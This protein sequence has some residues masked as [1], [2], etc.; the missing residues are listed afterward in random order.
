MK[1]LSLFLLFLVS[2]NIFAFSLFG[3]KNYDECIL[4]NMKGVSSDIAARL[5]NNSCDEKFKEKVVDNSKKREWIL[6][7]TDDESSF[8][9]DKS[10][11]KRYGNV[12]TVVDLIDFNDIQVDNKK[13]Q[14]YSAILIAE[15]DCKNEKY[16]FISSTEKSGHMGEGE[17]FNVNNIV[18]EYKKLTKES[19]AHK[20]DCSN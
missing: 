10:T 15:V 11:I 9:Y 2:T 3:P 8:Y 6:I 19:H 1:I 20:I 13:S 4:E 5:V 12:V 16:R 14:Y 7:G 17:S 18:G